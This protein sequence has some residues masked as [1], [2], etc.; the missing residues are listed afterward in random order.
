MH[1]L[2]YAALVVFTLPA[3]AAAQDPPAGDDPT[4]FAEALLA[5]QPATMT[6]PHPLVRPFMVMHTVKGDEKGRCRY[7]QTMPGEMTMECAFSEDGRKAMAEEIRTLAGGTTL[8]GSTK[9]P[10]PAWTKECEIVTKDG[11]RM[12]FGR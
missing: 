7:D 3:A 8:H 1:M 4:A 12:P 2:R 10:Q 11:K 9:G 5:C 6:I